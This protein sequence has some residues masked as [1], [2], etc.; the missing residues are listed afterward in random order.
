MLLFFTREAF[1]RF[2]IDD[3]FEGMG[4]ASSSKGIRFPMLIRPGDV[5][6]RPCQKRRGEF[7]AMPSLGEGLKGEDSPLKMLFYTSS[8]RVTLAMNTSH[9]LFPCGKLGEFLLTA[10]GLNS[11]SGRPTPPSTLILAGELPAPP[12]WMRRGCTCCCD[13]VSE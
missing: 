3:R 1:L 4:E 7:V 12:F 2:S 9:T 8:T 13:I 5:G 10:I 6:S 11:D